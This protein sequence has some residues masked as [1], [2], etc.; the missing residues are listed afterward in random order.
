M[1]A[2]KTQSFN[3]K[4][5]R[6]DTEREV[7]TIPNILTSTLVLPLAS[8]LIPSLLAEIT[9]FNI[10]PDR[11][12]VAI[13]S[14]LLFKRVYLYSTAYNALDWCA[15]RNFLS[16]PSSFSLPEAEA[17]AGAEVEG[18]KESNEVGLGTRISAI[19]KELFADF[20]TSQGNKG[21]QQM[22][23]Q[24]IYV[25]LD[26]IDGYSQAL[27][28]PILI[29]T[30]LVTTYAVQSANSG[31]LASSWILQ[32]ITTS[33]DTDHANTE[34][35]MLLAQKVSIVLPGLISVVVCSLFSRIEIEKIFMTTQEKS[36]RSVSG[37]V[38]L[39]LA[40]LLSLISVFYQP[41]FATLG[42]SAILMSNIWLL[43]N[44]LNSLLAVSISRVFS[45]NKLQ[46]ISI[47][48]TG[49]VF[50]DY[51]FVNGLSQLTDGGTSI[52]EAVATAK[53]QA[54]DT[55]SSA[56]TAATTTVASAAS[57]SGVESGLE[58]GL[59][60]I[61][62]SLRV[63]SPGFFQVQVG[64]KVSD[65]LGLGDVVF[66]S[67]LASWALKFDNRHS[68]AQASEGGGNDSKMEKDRK[69][70]GD[71]DSKQLLLYPSTLVGFLVGCLLCEVFQTGSGQ[72]ALLYVVPGMF[73]GMMGK[74][75]ASEGVGEKAK[76]FLAEMTSFTG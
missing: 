19:N 15:K 33:T 29:A 34:A 9:D 39:G 61:Q 73:A 35:L 68:T 63:W 27:L 31:M 50:Y 12:Q 8:T 40:I 20:S 70:G 44:M 25:G 56:S 62:S 13:I 46:Y 64:G 71:G 51:F 22:E 53:L 2:P 23:S 48:L 58:Q 59:A 18:N 38:S 66:P 14:L 24:Q 36:K 60:A 17:E 42:A 45:F 76:R 30:S 43:Q 26:S 41:L 7:N 69:K 67:M 52:M 47:A 11:R 32:A 3:L 5:F 37:I 1:R 72:P 21:Q 54:A 49:L 55:L 4:S 6:V 28:V 75:L 57:V 74:V 16:P 65:G 10:E